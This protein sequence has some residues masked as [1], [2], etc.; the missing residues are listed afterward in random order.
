MERIRAEYAGRINLVV[1]YFPLPGH[2]NGE[3]AAR[4]AEAAARQGKFEA[5]YA[6]RRGA[7]RLRPRPRTPRRR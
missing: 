4:A 6:E 2:R 5:M 1:R 3:L 7:L